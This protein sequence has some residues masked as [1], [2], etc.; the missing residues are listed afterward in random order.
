MRPLRYRPEEQDIVITNGLNRFN[1]PLYGTN[2][3]FF[4]YAGDK[5]EILLSL[6]GKGGTLWLGIVAAGGG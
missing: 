5:P 4:V 2:S 3:A 6:P 1:R